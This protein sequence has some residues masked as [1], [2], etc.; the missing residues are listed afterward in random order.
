MRA[1]LAEIFR[2]RE[3]PYDEVHRFFELK[4]K[5]I[6]KQPALISILHGGMG[7]IDLQGQAFI[8][9]RP[10]ILNNIQLVTICN[11]TLIAGPTFPEGEFLI[12]SHNS[13]GIRFSNLLL[14]CSKRAS[15]IHLNKF[16]RTRIEDCYIV[17]QKEFGIYASPTGGNHELEI[18]KCHICEYLFGDGR[19]GKRENYGVIPEFDIDANR[20]STGIFLGQA[21]N[22]V[23]EC[24]INLCRVGIFSG[25]RANRIQGN[26]ITGGGSRELEIFK[27]IELNNF[28]KSSAMIVNNY[29]DNCCLWINC[30]SDSTKNLRNYF[31][32]TDNLF[33]RGYNHPRA[34][35]EFN[36]IVINPLEPGS[37][38]SNLHICDN[39][40][41]NQPENLEE[42]KP[43]V[44][45]PIRINNKPDAA[46]VDPAATAAELPSIDHSS[47]IGVTVKNNH[48]T[49]C[50]PTFVVPMGSTITKTVET[51]PDKQSYS[52]SF[53]DEMPLGYINTAEAAV[54]GFSGEV[55]PTVTVRRIKQRTVLVAVVGGGEATISVTASTDA[56]Y[57]ARYNYIVR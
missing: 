12:R 37:L 7:V 31:H 53:G 30:D 17:H 11:G 56:P 34:G 13:Y 25:M 23:A 50:F 21:D 24:N 51:S 47:L 4:I 10:L 16:L 45:R 29:I 48:F 41:Y 15:G 39:L 55:P 14:E 35:G 57:N 20:V 38:I 18:I 9:D 6:T 1:T 26:H 40:F 46:S 49:N 42:I 19:P 8:L 27:G 28:H 3:H 33:Y 36:H 22:V 54:I 43:R 52:V 44:I 32:V 2:T 5:E